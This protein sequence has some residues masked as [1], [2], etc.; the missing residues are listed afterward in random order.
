M[1]LNSSLVV[2]SDDCCN[3]ARF[4]RFFRRFA[5]ADSDLSLIDQKD[6]RNLTLT[7]GIPGKSEAEY[8][9]LVEGKGNVTVKLDCAK[10][11]KHTQT[12]ALK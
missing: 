1:F 5:A 6:L 7:S 12:I 9:F 10:G 11:G 2:P 3:P 4:R 8:Q